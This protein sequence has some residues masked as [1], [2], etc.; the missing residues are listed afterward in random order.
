MNTL[1]LLLSTM[2]NSNNTPKGPDYGHFVNLVTRCSPCILT[3]RKDWYPSGSSPKGV[4]LSVV[5][6]R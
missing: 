1:L 3:D 4:S 6:N 2:D 5:S